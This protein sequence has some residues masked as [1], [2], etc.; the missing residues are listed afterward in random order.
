MVSGREQG[1]Q[2]TPR[3]SQSKTFFITSVWLSLATRSVSTPGRRLISPAPHPKAMAEGLTPF[4]GLSGPSQR[5]FQ[6]GP[7]RRPGLLRI[8]YYV[9]R[10][11]PAGAQPSDIAS[12][13]RQTSPR[14]VRIVGLLAS[15]HTRRVGFL[16]ATYRADIMNRCFVLTTIVKCIRSK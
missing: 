9:V 4:P 1:P 7:A 6:A 11:P 2:F 13:Y 8:R 15:E 14:S 3:C 10:I 16:S 12:S 5:E